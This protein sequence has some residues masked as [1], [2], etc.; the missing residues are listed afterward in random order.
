MRWVGVKFFVMVLG[1]I[2]KCLFCLDGVGDGV[3]F[4]F[5]YFYL[6]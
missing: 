2:Y 3:E 6:W 5:V 1:N 4:Y